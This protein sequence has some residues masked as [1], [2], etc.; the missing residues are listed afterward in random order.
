[1]VQVHELLSLPVAY[2]ANRVTPPQSVLTLMT[3]I[4]ANRISKQT[5]I[6][7]SKTQT[8]RKQ[9]TNPRTLLKN[10]L[11]LLHHHLL[12]FLTSKQGQME[13]QSRPQ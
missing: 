4:L 13:L 10:T 1:M 7:H 2:E 3:S 11:F 6:P 8:I 9:A 12:I 5:I